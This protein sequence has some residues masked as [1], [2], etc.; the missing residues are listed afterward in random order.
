MCPRASFRLAA[1]AVAAAVLTSCGAAS[2]TP[3]QAAEPATSAPPSAHPVSP[4]P[5]VGAVFLGADGVH[6][7]SASVLS[8]AVADLILT[9]AHCVADGVDATFIPG[10]TD[11]RSAE[12]SRHLDAVYLDPRWVRDRD[13]AADYAI[14]RVSRADGPALATVAG[15]GLRLDSAP[16]PGTEVTIVGYGYGVGGGPTA[17]T[18][19]TVAPRAGFP[20]VHCDGIVA[21]FSGAPWITGSTVVGVIGGLDGGGCLDEVSYSPRFDG[22]LQALLARAEAGGPADIPPAVF[23]DGCG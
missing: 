3:S 22:A 15:G 19:A 8:S 14:A 12:P 9:A 16:A 5:R 4:D 21:G 10:F 17:C 20:V 18:A 23:D 11:A 1:A 13:P 7:C 2:S 6:V